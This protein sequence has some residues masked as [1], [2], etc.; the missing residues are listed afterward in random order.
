VVFVIDCDFTFLMN[1]S[2]NEWVRLFDERRREWISGFC[3]D[4]NPQYVLG[5]D[6]LCRLALASSDRKTE[7]DFFLHQTTG[8]YNVT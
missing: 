4:E 1:C 5:Y 3:A 2:E 7:A 8:G 6:A